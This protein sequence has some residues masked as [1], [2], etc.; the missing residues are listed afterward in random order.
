MKNTEQKILDAATNLFTAKGFLATTTKEIAEAANVS[1]MT[2]F[3]KFSTKQNLLTCIINP[4]INNLRITLINQAEILDAHSFFYQLLDDRMDMIS[5]NES[6]VRM[7]VIEKT[8]GNLGESLDFPLIIFNELNNAVKLHFV[9]NNLLAD[10]ET[11]V[12]ILIGLLLTHVVFPISPPYYE[13]PN[14]ERKVL[15][16]SML[17]HIFPNDGSVHN[18][19]PTG[20]DPNVIKLAFHK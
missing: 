10:S 14:S 4:I 1:E 15:L 9:K 16:D 3:R 8:L 5:R 6:L 20:S 2:L 12:R 18:A 19:L 11:I 13:L 17:H 7:I